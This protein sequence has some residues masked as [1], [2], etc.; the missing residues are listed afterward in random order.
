MLLARDIWQSATGGRPLLALQSQS[1]HGIQ[2]LCFPDASQ[3]LGVQVGLP[4]R[5]QLDARLRLDVSSG[6]VQGI[7]IV[8]V[9]INDRPLLP[10]L[11]SDLLPRAAAGRASRSRDEE[12]NAFLGAL[13]PWLRDGR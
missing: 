13:L 6:L 1:G 2:P 7:D 10:K 8:A 12:L 5:L 3:A 11:V 4:L 9:S